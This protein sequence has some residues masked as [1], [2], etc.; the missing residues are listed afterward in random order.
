MKKARVSIGYYN[1]TEEDIKNIYNMK[2]PFQVQ[3]LFTESGNSNI[4]EISTLFVEPDC[5]LSGY[6]SEVIQK[7]CKNNEDDIILVGAG[8]LSTEYTEEPST[9]E[10]EQLFDNL[11][12]FYN[13]NNFEDVTQLF[14]TYDGSTKRTFLYL[15]KAGKAAIE[16]RKEFIKERNK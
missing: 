7:I 15:N 5:R 10:Y 2:L 4:I 1:A 16:R 14:G 8:A 13:K 12:I 6:G 3:D 11:T 9:E